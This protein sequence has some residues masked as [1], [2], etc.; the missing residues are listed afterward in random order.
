MR[1]P[2]S[3][4]IEAVQAVLKRETPSRF[5]FAPNYWQWF[6]H[7]QNHN[8]VP[9][10]IAHCHTQLDLIK[11]LGL[12]V[13]SR[14]TYCDQKRCWFGGLARPI[15]DGVEVSANEYSQGS[16]RVFEKTYQTKAGNLTECLRYVADGSTLVQEKFPVDDYNSQL[17]AFEQLVSARRWEFSAD[18][19]TQQQQ[20]VGDD[21]IVI[22]GEL[23]SP[24]KLLHISLGPVNTTYLIADYPDRTGQIL[25]IHED[26]QLDLVRQMARANV[27][28]MMAVDNLDT[29]FHSPRYV[30][31]YS[32]G[33]YEKAARICHE[34][35][36]TFFIHACGQQKDNLKLISSLGVDGLEGVAFPPIGD[37]EL[38]EAMELSGDS[39]IITGG[40]SAAETE[41]LT[42]KKQIFAYVKNLLEAMR[43]YKH[44]FML[45]ASC[46]TPINTPWE[47]IKLFRDAWLEYK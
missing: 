29:M 26:A 3:S 7:Q 36:S 1:I 5:V 2:G 24:L 37:V 27:P 25:S 9:E 40:I 39:F 10:E 23:F 11:Y 35:G 19:Y 34:H 47:A 38:I 14:N 42:T 33:F 44:R 46:N 17:D 28:A 6:A 18:Q 20:K 13:F 41:K 30:E 32:A 8:T 16:D 4:G 43:P 31:N 45:S 22:A 15:F 21:G 12:D